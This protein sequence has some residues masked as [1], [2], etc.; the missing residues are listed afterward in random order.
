MRH[1]VLLILLPLSFSYVFSQSKKDESYYLFDKEGN[2]VSNI[3]KASTFRH[4]FKKNDTTWQHDYYN[5]FGPKIVEENYRDKEALVPNGYFAYF[6]ARGYMDSCGYVLNSRRHG[7]WSFF[8]ADSGKISFQKR[9]NYGKLQKTIDY[10]V[11]DDNPEDTS[12]VKRVEVESEFPGGIGAW[13]KH[14]N[15]NLRYPKRALDARV[16]GTVWVFFIVDQ[17]GIV[18]DINITKSV[19]FSIDEESIRV[20]KNTPNWVPAVQ[21]GRKVKSYKK[22]SI[23]FS[24]KSN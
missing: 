7:N 24:V 19:E 8:S 23:I 16:Q 21:D 10:S 1:I 9:Y 17:K 13:Q 11:K 5:L 4:V 22:Q 12:T 6:N 3:K 14:L 18:S 20:I 2:S 15:Q